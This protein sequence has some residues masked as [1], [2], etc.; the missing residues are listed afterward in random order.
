MNGELCL[1]KNKAQRDLI[2]ALI[3]L[4]WEVDDHRHEWTWHS[5]PGVFET[6]Y[7]V[8]C[9]TE[10]LW[11]IGNENQYRHEYHKTCSRQRAWHHR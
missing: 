8:W 3:P 5:E 9:V 1:K 11:R 7:A 4:F 6:S 10:L 2:A